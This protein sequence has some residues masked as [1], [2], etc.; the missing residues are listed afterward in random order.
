MSQTTKKNQ[1]KSRINQVG[2]VGAIDGAA[3]TLKI[4]AITIIIKNIDVNH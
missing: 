1:K 4:P 2:A 3:G